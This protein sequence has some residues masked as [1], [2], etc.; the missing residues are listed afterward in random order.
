MFGFLFGIKLVVVFLFVGS[1]GVAAIVAFHHPHPH[2][3]AHKA[4]GL[5]MTSR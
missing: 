3:A 5:A 1:I 2:P 4:V